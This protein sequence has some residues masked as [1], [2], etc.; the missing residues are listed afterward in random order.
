MKVNLKMRA[1]VEG[2]K[3]RE[4]NVIKLYKAGFRN[5]KLFKV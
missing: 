1:E 3:E 5:K 2:G 4:R